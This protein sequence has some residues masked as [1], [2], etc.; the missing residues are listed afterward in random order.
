MIPRSYYHRNLFDEETKMPDKD[1]EKRPVER[2]A[3]CPKPFCLSVGK[4][5]VLSHLCLKVP[6][7]GSEEQDLEQHPSSDTQDA[8]GIF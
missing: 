3:G 2:H 1:E 4:L 7:Q 8:G 6:E 5:F